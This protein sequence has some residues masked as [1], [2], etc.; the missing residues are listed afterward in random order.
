MFYK[1]K[2]FTINRSNRYKNTPVICQMYLFAIWFEVEPKEK[3][4]IS[5]IFSNYLDKIID[6]IIGF[7]NF[8]VNQYIVLSPLLYIYIYICIYKIINRFRCFDKL[9]VQECSKSETLIVYVFITT[10]RTPPIR[11]HKLSM[12]QTRFYEKKNYLIPVRSINY[13][14]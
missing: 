6:E 3:N 11:A 10:W 13:F 4:I 9:T 5:K 2:R 12:A 14:Y 8:T 7:L 1:H